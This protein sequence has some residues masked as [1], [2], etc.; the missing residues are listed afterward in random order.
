MKKSLKYI[1]VFSLILLIVFTTLFSLSI[2]ED[3]NSI[4]ET[5]TNIKYIVKSY[6]GKIAVFQNN[7]SSPIKIV[8]VYI[9]LLPQSDRDI[10]NNGITV[11]NI[12]E[13]NKMLSDY[14]KY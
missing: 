14:S 11:S 9:D 12:D 13:V 8:D 1:I 2:A 10:L 6:E 4:S 5:T 7:E 3:K